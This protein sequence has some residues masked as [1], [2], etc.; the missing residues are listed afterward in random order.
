MK[1]VD[2]IIIGAGLTG[3]TCAHYLNRQGKDFLLLER[4]QRVGGAIKSVQQ[5]PFL[6]EAGPNTG[7]ISNQELTELLS[8]LKDRCTVEEA[9]A[10]VN[11]RHIL[12]K[13]RWHALPTGA[14]SAITTPL[15][16]L[17]DKFRILGEPFRKPGKD[18]DESVSSMVTRRLGSSFLDYAI[19]P[20]I[21]GIYA[22]QTDTLTVRYALPK[23]YEL[24]QRYGSFIKGAINKR[25]EAKKA[26]TPRPSKAIFSIA[27]GLEELP[28][29]MYQSF[30]EQ[31]VLNCHDIQVKPLPEGGFHVQ[32]QGET[33]NA[34][35]VITTTGSYELPHLLPF[36]NKD[37][38]S[39]LNNLVYAPVV[40][41][42]LGFKEWL[43]KP[44]DGFGGLIPSKEKRTILGVLYLSS[45][46]PNRAPVGGALLTIFMGGM[47]HPEAIHW[48]REEIH[49]HVIK[50][51]KELYQLPHCS[52]EL[53]AIHYHPQAI[54][55]YTVESTQRIAALSEV[56][57][58]YPGLLLGGNIHQGVGIAD[59]IKQGKILAERVI[60]NKFNN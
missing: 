30:R 38:L 9:G 53:F 20:F 57:K 22:G 56:E 48:D 21:G 35:Q 31:V 4:S 5:G 23:L 34:S 40:T 55:Q 28:Q 25:K 8:E 24:E 17:K 1:H 15:F 13:G 12:K 54:A 60:A 49:A 39:A 18:P 50:E 45:F 11:K 3:L 37:E 59:R 16:S 7:V 14:I 32:T 29:A 43:G 47:N 6:Y 2:T 51:I 33:I 36:L 41:V 10:E 42:S 46:L 44:L 27:G 52:P 26:Q 58:N 19:D